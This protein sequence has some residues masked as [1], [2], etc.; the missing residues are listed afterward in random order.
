MLINI[1]KDIYEQIGFKSVTRNRTRL[2]YY[3]I[4]HPSKV[5]SNIIY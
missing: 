4:D 1:L 5:H 2:Y 3:D